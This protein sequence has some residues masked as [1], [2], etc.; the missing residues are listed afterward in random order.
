[1]THLLLIPVFIDVVL[2]RLVWDPMAP[3]V[4]QWRITLN[5]ARL[6]LQ[7]EIRINC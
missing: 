7:T 6:V 2:V 3:A 5:A 1:M 4:T